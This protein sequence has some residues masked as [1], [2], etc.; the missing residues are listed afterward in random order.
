MS[1]TQ[2]GG[3]GCSGD[4]LGAKCLR[5]LI[6]RMCGWYPAYVKVHQLW[7]HDGIQGEECL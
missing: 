2:S 1:T 7:L 5:L 3:A 6:D 4:V